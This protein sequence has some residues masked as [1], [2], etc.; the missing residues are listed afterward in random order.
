MYIYYMDSI[1][2]YN[3]QAMAT[4]TY[5]VMQIAGSLEESLH[6]FKC[7]VSFDIT[8]QLIDITQYP[9]VDFENS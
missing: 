3:K 7:T 5:R 2:K 4:R 1:I 8:Q 9:L 6:K